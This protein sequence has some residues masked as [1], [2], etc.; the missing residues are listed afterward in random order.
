[1][2]EVETLG[3]L[4]KALPGIQQLLE[5]YARS[6]AEALEKLGSEEED[7]ARRSR[8]D[9]LRSDAL[10]LAAHLQRTYLR[11]VEEALEEL[12][13]LSL[14]TRMG[15]L[16]LR[17]LERFKPDFTP[18]DLC[19]AVLDDLLGATQARRGYLVLTRGSVGE[20]E[21]V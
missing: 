5:G 15:R 19:R 16:A 18:L 11:Q 8:F 12:S 6:A 9:R 14:Q 4:R 10:G 20:V 13:G 17:L 2:S 1:M 3:K 21:V 7:P